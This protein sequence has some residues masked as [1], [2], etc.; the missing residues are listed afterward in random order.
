[1]I[2][3]PSEIFGHPITST[4]EQAITDRTNRWCPFVDKICYKQSRMVDIPFGVCSAHYRESELALCPRKFLDRHQVFT[5]IALKHFGSTND[6]LVFSEIRLKGIGSFDFVMV[7]HKPLSVEIEDFAVI[8]FQTGQTTQTGGLVQGF[9]D[10]FEGKSIIYGSYRFGVNYYDI[11]KR[12]FTQV[13]SKGI[14]L[15]NWG[16]RIYWVVQEPI[17]D[18]FETRN[19]L[20][21]IPLDDKSSTVF[22]LYDLVPSSNSFDLRLSRSKSVSVDQLFSAFRNNPAIPPVEEFIQS[23]QGRIRN[24]TELSLSLGDARARGSID[25]KPPAASG[26]VRELSFWDD[27]E[28]SGQMQG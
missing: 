17:F 9:K 27:E 10:F 14:I 16:H 12:T 1:M 28:L 20:K 6:I 21:D 25:V 26:K 5:D 18:F 2:R 19:H 23:I 24:H 11:W 15:E 13:L 3:Y 8:E 4:T 22:V 7:K